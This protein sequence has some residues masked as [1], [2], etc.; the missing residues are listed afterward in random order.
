M[1][2]VLHF[3]TTYRNYAE[4]DRWTELAEMQRAPKPTY[5]SSGRAENIFAGCAILLAI[6]VVVAV[7][8]A[9]AWQR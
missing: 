3:T 6:V 5:R 8:C 9:N 7:A 2:K 1:A 4:S